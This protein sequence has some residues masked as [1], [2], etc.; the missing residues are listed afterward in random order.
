MAAGERSCYKAYVV[1][2]ILGSKKK[3]KEEGGKYKGN[4]GY[5]RMDYS[6]NIPQSHTGNKSQQ[7]GRTTCP[8]SA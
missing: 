7:T 6:N 1:D 5:V 4:T 8:R 3:R 2:L